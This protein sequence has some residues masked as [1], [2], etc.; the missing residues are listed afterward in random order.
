MPTTSSSRQL[1][2]CEPRPPSGWRPSAYYEEGRITIDRFL[3]AV[4]QYAQAVATEAEYKTL[5]NISIIVFEEAKGTLL[6]Y[7]NI[8]VAEGPHPRKAYVQAKDIQNAHRKLPIPH[9]GPTYNPPVSG[10]VNPDPVPS[11][12]PPGLKPGQVP[13]LP[14]PAGPLGPNATPLPPFRP[15]GEPPILSHN[16]PAG[17]ARGGLR[18]TG[19]SQALRPHGR[20]PVNA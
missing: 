11:Y 1:H 5:Y 14:A 4:S 17:A 10:P 19:G 13:N 3:D 2:A 15:A 6:S 18:R 9:D 20:E 12:P 8:A 7:N 16:A